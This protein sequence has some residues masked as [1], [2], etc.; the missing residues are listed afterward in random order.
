MTERLALHVRE[1]LNP[2][3]GWLKGYDH[4]EACR[5][6][7]APAP[8]MFDEGLAYLDGRAERGPA[9]IRMADQARVAVAVY[10]R[11]GTY[12]STKSLWMERC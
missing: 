7:H 3:A 12:R 4:G 2:D 1:E 8:P 10:V 9:S 5:L 6:V 11:W